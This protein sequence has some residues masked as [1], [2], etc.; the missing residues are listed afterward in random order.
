MFLKYANV[1]E[2]NEQ[3]KNNTGDKFII[4]QLIS[5]QENHG[6]SGVVQNPC[7]QN[8]HQLKSQGNLKAATE[9][10]T[11]TE[12]VAQRNVNVMLM[13]FSTH[14]KI[15]NNNRRKSFFFFKKRKKEK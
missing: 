6:G 15:N 12:N 3:H 7:H 9:I 11:L 10:P 5:F 13:L 8:Y 14:V 2:N 1:L 4:S